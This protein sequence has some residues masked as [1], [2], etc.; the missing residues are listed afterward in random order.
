MTQTQPCLKEVVHQNVRAFNQRSIQEDMRNTTCCYHH[1]ASLRWWV[2]QNE[3]EIFPK[4]HNLPFL[5]HHKTEDI[6]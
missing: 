5:S 2:S 4:G 3:Q 1:H 6:F